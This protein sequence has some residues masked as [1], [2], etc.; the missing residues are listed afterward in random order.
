MAQEQQKTC[1][2]L[3]E[4]DRVFRN[5]YAIP[6]LMQKDSKGGYCGGIL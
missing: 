2:N 6:I 4:A 5:I 1:M 3:A